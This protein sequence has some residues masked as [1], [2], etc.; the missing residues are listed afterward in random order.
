MNK[1]IILIG[2]FTETIELC[3]SCGYSI[4]GVIDNE[5]NGSYCGYPILGCDDD[6]G[7]LAKKYR[8]VLLVISPDSSAAKRKLYKKYSEIGFSFATVISPR[9]YI[10]KS[11]C[12]G[13]GCIIQSGVNISSNAV[14]GKF[15]KL[16][17]NCNIMHDVKIGSFS[18]I[19]PNAV[20]LG[21]SIIG[22]GVYI[23][24]NATVEHDTRIDDGF[25]VA[26]ATYFTSNKL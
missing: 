22:E 1:N 13:E 9:A 15:C 25:K 5:V 23:G 11:A 19:A 17:T 2:A 14:I 7:I 21:R 8:D 16:N 10:S 20:V 3:E 24:A 6:A 26:T 18:I 12:V 4:I